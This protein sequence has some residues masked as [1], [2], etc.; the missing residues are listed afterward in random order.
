MVQIHD[1]KSPQQLKKMQLVGPFTFTKNCKILKIKADYIGLPPNIDIEGDWL[2]FDL[3]S[4]PNQNSPTSNPT[5]ETHLIREMKRLMRENDSPSE[6]FE[7]L[8]L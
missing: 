2:L 5:I 1:H 8:G 6:Q 4:D 7:R 3:K